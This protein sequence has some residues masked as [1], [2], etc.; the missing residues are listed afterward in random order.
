MLS[1]LCR[2]LTPI[3]MAVLTLSPFQMAI[4]VSIGGRRLFLQIIYPKIYFCKIIKIN[5][6]INNIPLVA[7]CAEGEPCLLCCGP[8][9]RSRPKG[10]LRRP[11]MLGRPGQ[12]AFAAGRRGHS[13]T[14]RLGPKVA[15]RSCDFCGIRRLGFRAKHAVD[16]KLLGRDFAKQ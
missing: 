15:S 12:A 2:A 4:A 11:G 14:L 8:R 6:K 13:D 5:I 9:L 10:T 1:C 16:A 3:E 7:S